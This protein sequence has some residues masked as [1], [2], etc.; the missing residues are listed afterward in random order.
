MTTLAGKNVHVQGA[1]KDRL[2]PKTKSFTRKG[3]LFDRDELMALY[4]QRDQ[5][6]PTRAEAKLIFAS[7]RREGSLGLKLRQSELGWYWLRNISRADL[8][9]LLTELARDPNPLVRWPAVNVLGLAQYERALRL[10]K[11]LVSDGRVEVAV[12]AVKGLARFPATKVVP[13]LRRISADDAVPSQV[14]RQAAKALA[15][16]DASRASALIKRLAVDALPSMRQLAVELMREARLPNDAHVLRSLAKDKSKRV[17]GVALVVLAKSG[18]A[19]DRDWIADLAASKGRSSQPAAIRALGEFGDLRDVPLL[20]K[21]AQEGQWPVRCAVSEILVRYPCQQAVDLLKDLTRAMKC[22]PAFDSLVR[23]PANL[24]AK[25]IRELAKDKN[26]N[27]RANLATRLGEWKHPSVRTMLR[28]LAEDRDFAVRTGAA[29]SLGALGSVKD[30]PLL[31][32]MCRDENDWVRKEAVWTVGTFG[33]TADI[34]LLKSLAFDKCA[35][36]RALAARA[37]AATATRKELLPWLGENIGQLSFEALTELDYRLYAPAWLRNT[38]RRADY[39]YTLM[40]V[41]VYRHRAELTAAQAFDQTC[42]WH[43]HR[44]MRTRNNT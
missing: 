36:V 14:R 23:L 3:S 10:F 21:L 40:K 16:L 4:R 8:C 29:S 24:T 11:T 35:E 31:R 5:F 42:S 1:V 9:S 17:R 38:E 20:S 30:L 41:G 6:K 34:P 19:A 28:Q 2:S 7:M 33:Q 32:R 12:E 18:R 37:L 22:G 39:D 25:A 15:Q 44:E 13:V 43:R 27:V 26:G